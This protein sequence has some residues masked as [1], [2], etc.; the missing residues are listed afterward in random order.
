MRH[1]INTFVCATSLFA[2]PTP[3]ASADPPLK[4]QFSGYEW[5]VKQSDSMGPGPNAWNPKNVWVDAKG[6]LHLKISN[7]DGKWEC[8]EVASTQRFGFG[9]YEF[10]IS[11]A[12]DKLDQQIVL[13]LFN[14][15]T[16][17][18]GVDG[19]NE[20]DIEFAHWGNAKWPNGNFTV[21]PPVKEVKN[22]SDTFNFTL[23][24]EDST[25]QFTWTQ[26]SVGFESK[27]GDG[28]K[29]SES[30]HKWLYEPAEFM[31]RIP[32]NPEPVLMNLWLFRGKPPTDGKEVEIVVKR[33]KFTAEK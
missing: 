27:T 13:G 21:W 10:Q 19:T 5:T 15:P 1:L 18:V 12:I 23:K 11:G 2:L 3:R 8:G 24:Q 4:I 16:R 30:I 32:Q 14:Y 9:T 31:T 17:D 26:R 7:H 25:H 29:R 28:G 6:Q 20:I 22:G 33:F